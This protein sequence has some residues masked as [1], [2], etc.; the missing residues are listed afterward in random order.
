MIEKDKVAEVTHRDSDIDFKVYY[1]LD[2]DSE[3]IDITGI[4]IYASQI[5]LV[6][7][8]NDFVLYDIEEELCEKHGFEL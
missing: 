4:Y 2:T 1:T 7:V 8:V 6:E 3:E 5:D